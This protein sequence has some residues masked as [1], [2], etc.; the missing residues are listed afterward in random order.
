MLI[1]EVPLNRTAA[2]KKN[3]A[4]LREGNAS[5]AVPP[6]RV[7]SLAAPAV[8]MAR[9]SLAPGEIPQEWLARINRASKRHMVSEALLAA[10]LRVES[11]FNPNAV[12]PKGAQGAM[13]I[14][15]ATGRALGLKDF[16][17][18]EENLDAGARYLAALLLEFSRPELALAAYNAG[19]EAV[20]RY[21][22]I[23]P[24]QETKHYVEQVIAS[25][26]S[27]SGRLR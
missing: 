19:P 23:P 9:L 1:R 12:S 25:F 7:S 16:F 15:P 27:Y 14:M 4:L 3:T 10:V 2:W 5:R 24:Y 6:L 20:R 18:P 21:G 22:G 8:L 26:K 17:D 11:N 13:Q